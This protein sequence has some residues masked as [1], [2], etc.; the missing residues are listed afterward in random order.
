MRLTS[1]AIKI[2]AIIFLLFLTLLSIGCSRTEQAISIPQNS[3]TNLLINNV[4]II[5][6]ENERIIPNRQIL[7]KDGTISAIRAAGSLDNS[8]ASIVKD[9]KGG[10]IA[11]GLIDMHV[12]AYDK[13]AFE[14]SLSHGVTHVRVM[15]GVKQHLQWRSEQQAGKWLASGMTVSSPIIHSGDS[16]PL[17]WTANSEQEARSLVRQAKR[18]GYDLIKAYGSLSKESLLAII[19]ESKKLS[20]PV[21]K[22][23][24]HPAPGMHWQDLAG[25]QSL[26]HVEDIY[27]GPLAY[28]H[29]EKKLKP[30]LAN[31]QQV[32]TSVT[33]TLNI[34]WQL[35]QIS[36]NKQAFLDDLPQD[37]ISPI[38][39]WEAKS[40]QVDR[41]LN[42]SEKMSKHNQKTFDFLS[43]ITFALEDKNI[44]ILMGSDAGV[45][46]SPHGLATHNE[47]RL[48]K[49][50]GLSAFSVLRSATILPAKALGKEHEIGQ[51]K[52]GLKADLILTRHNPL[53]ALNVLKK[54]I[55]VVRQGQWL[56]EDDLNRLRDHAIKQQ[57][58][59]SELKVILTNY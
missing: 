21:A 52:V 39:A 11:P 8:H 35:S 27:Q 57:S 46:L 24:P 47:L 59:W 53:Q 5:D 17:S 34:F 38:I 2:I 49:Q 12:H 15:N 1:Q 43:E 26:E 14:L 41:W 29:D 55:A 30:V 48:L 58:W 16:Q 20:L 10:F 9:A 18:Q 50:S 36:K 6:V 22:H 37:Y 19:D 31:L 32:G 3:R 44:P 7:V 40:N 13:S 33:P 28:N 4:N 54:P 51:V 25:L 42:S 23:G 45:L 56:A